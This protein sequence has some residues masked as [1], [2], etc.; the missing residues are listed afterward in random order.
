MGDSPVTAIAHPQCLHAPHHRAPTV[1]DNR[2][3]QEGRD[4]FDVVIV[5]GGA[6]GCAVAAFVLGDPA[7]GG[8][9]VIVERDPTYRQASSALLAS[10]IR[11]QFSTPE[12]IRM[13]RIG[14]EFLRSLASGP[15]PVDVGLEEG[16]YL[17]LARPEGAPRSGEVHAVQRA[18]GAD[19][20]C[21]TAESSPRV[22]L[23]AFD[24]VEAGS[25]GLA[26]EGWFDGF[27]LL[28]ALRHRAIALGVEFVRD[29]VVGL[30]R[31]TGRTMASGW[32][33]ADASPPERS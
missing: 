21:S 19:V 17:Y 8:R 32:P 12:N 16:G 18:E 1:N 29:E 11:Q 27:G 26:G 7:F 5:G 9:V 24:H 30:D 23:D 20:S 3:M 2:G 33:P 31:G 14:F 22:S 13:S 28:Q 15:E 10:S 6:M 25:L 4:E